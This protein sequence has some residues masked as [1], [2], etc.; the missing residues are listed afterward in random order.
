MGWF[1]DMSTAD[2]IWTG[3]GLTGQLM[4]SMR[5]IYQWFKSEQ[6]KRSVV[7]EAFWYFS[8]FGGI[9][10][11]IYALRQRD[12][13]FSIGQ[14]TGL[15]IYLRNIWLIWKE[16]GRLPGQAPAETPEGSGP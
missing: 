6:A 15:L 16:K 11:F 12:L 4:F 2:M 3:I 14:G 1:R 7:P 5:F 10:L 8:L 13:V 9:T